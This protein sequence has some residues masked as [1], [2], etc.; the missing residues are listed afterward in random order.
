[1]EMK[2]LLWVLTYAIHSTALILSVWVITRV[3]GSLSLGT[4]ETLWK[5]ALLGG[6]ATASLQLASG[7]TPPWGNFALPAALDTDPVATTTHE[8]A[9]P[10]AD[11]AVQRRI[12]Q[13]DAG[14]LTITTISE[15]RPTAATHTVT[16]T[17]PME[18]SV[19][20]WVLLGLIG[21][22]SVFALG[23]LGLAARRLKAKLANRRDVI[24]DPVLDGYLT[25][26]QKAELTDKKKVRLTASSHLRS[27]VAL[28]NREVVIPERAIDR[29]TQQQQQSM[30][31]HEL[32]HVIRRDPQ[33]SLFT[34]IVEAIFF[35]QPLNHLAR[36][37]IAETAEF[38]CDDWAARQVGTGVHLAK[39]LAEVAAWIESGSGASP[40]AVSMAEE[41]SPIVRRITRLLNRRRKLDDAESSTAFALRVGTTV[42]LLG[43]AVWLIP[44][45]SRGAHEVEPTAADPSALLA[46]A[47]AMATLAEGEPQRDIVIRD[48]RGEDGRKYSRVL[49]ERDDEIVRVEV[50]R[51]DAP[52]PTPEPSG[53]VFSIHGFVD[54]PFSG[55]CGHIEIEIDDEDF[56]VDLEGMFSAGFPFSSGCDHGDRGGLD[57]FF[58]HGP[59]GR[60]HDHSERHRSRME[61]HQARMERHRDRLERKR[62][63]LERKADRLRAK[64]ERL[65]E[66]PQVFDL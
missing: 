8:V 57:V 7:V 2:I 25:L 54:D 17:A 6:I 37:K 38:Q 28:R 42:G 60:R 20:P 46:G 66:S 45:V 56:D 51:A 5:A 52:P 63:K 13:H 65:A 61:R 33:W 47:L 3:F 50:D 9:A 24:E 26:C 58:G 55:G 31:A 32:A 35:F 30:L 18:P 41:G 44:G 27:P 14:D 11:A 21:I 48:V 16:A 64:A 23:R 59:R 22:G 19:W 62:E 29:L 36:R 12:V 34:A 39:C 43:A 40:L 1:M 49:I 15:S 10:V 53:G 4:K